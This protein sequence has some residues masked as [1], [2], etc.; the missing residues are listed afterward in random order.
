MK[1]KILIALSIVFC[2]G[3][4]TVAEAGVTW[5]YDNWLL[6]SGTEIYG[7][8]FKPSG[9]VYTYEAGTDNLTK[10][11]A[12]AYVKI[13]ATSAGN[14]I[15]KSVKVGVDSY[16]AIARASASNAQAWGSGH[17]TL[18]DADRYEWLYLSTQ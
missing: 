18:L 2:L 15:D 9:T 1:G 14:T 16:N 5:N 8:L 13:Y 7:Y 11:S 3:V 10:N 6:E 4:P 12:G 17:S